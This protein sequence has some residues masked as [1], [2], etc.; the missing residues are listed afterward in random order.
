MEGQANCLTSSF[1]FC[2][3][4]THTHIMIKSW[5]MWWMGCM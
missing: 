4:H 1:I 3:L 5:R 2:T